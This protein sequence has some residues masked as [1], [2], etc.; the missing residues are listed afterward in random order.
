MKCNKCNNE[1]PS[2]SKFCPIC[3]NKIEKIEEKKKIKENVY[4]E[5]KTILISFKKAILGILGILIMILIILAVVFFKKI[6]NNINKPIAIKNDQNTELYE[7][8]QIGLFK[9]PNVLEEKYNNKGDLIYCKYKQGHEIKEDSY[10]YHYD[11]K[12]RT[13][14]ITLN[15]D[16]SSFSINYNN[17]NKISEINIGY[18]LGTMKYIF[19]YNDDLIIAEKYNTIS[20]SSYSVN[21]KYNGL[22]MISE[23]EIDGKTYILVT[24]TDE[25]DIVKT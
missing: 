11:S 5:K 23:K 1:I 19:H 4:E 15:G 13:T 24:E 3:R 7:R 10:N 17:E 25:T 2:D 9:G 6:N 18:E 20:M 12:E 8:N 22:V 21:N 16:E 14:K